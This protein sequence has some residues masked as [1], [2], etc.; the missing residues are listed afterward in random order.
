MQAESSTQRTE[1]TC[2]I[3]CVNTFNMIG[4]FLERAFLV[5]LAYA[6]LARL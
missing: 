3:S 1:I 4:K 5:G 2:Q 6:T